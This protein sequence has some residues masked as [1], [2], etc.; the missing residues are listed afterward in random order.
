MTDKQKI[1]LLAKVLD[2]NISDMEGLDRITYPFTCTVNNV[3]YAVVTT[4]ELFDLIAE[5]LRRLKCKNIQTRPIYG[6][7]ED[8]LLENCNQSKCE[9]SCIDWIKSVVKSYTKDNL[10]DFIIDLRLDADEDVADTAVDSLSDLPQSALETLAYQLYKE[11]IDERY[12]GNYLEWYMDETEQ[13]IGEV[14]A[15]GMT[16]FNTYD[17]AEYIINT[18][19]YLTNLM[20]H[21]LGYSGVEYFDAKAYILVDY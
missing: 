8:W 16:S 11:K 14:L 9:R 19:D 17:L 12:E 15:E 20:V 7:I 18:S 2:C 1:K 21:E 13:T 3:E 5:E 6:E 10:I 4:S